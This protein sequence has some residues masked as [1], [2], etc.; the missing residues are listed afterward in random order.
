M[1]SKR[2]LSWSKRSSS[3]EP[4]YRTGGLLPIDT[5]ATEPSNELDAKTALKTERP[6]LVIL[7]PDKQQYDLSPVTDEYNGVLASSPLNPSRSRLKQIEE[8][9]STTTPDLTISKLKTQFSRLR[10]SHEAKVASLVETHQTEVAS[11]RN[12][13]RVLEE[14][15]GRHELH[16]ASIDS[17]P[18]VL[19]TTGSTQIPTRA[20][21]QNKPSHAAAKSLPSIRGPFEGRQTPQNPQENS[22]MVFLRRKLSIPQPSE[23]ETRN[24]APELNQ[25]K[26]NNV[27]LQGQIMS[28]MAKLTES[29]KNERELRSTLGMTEMRCAEWEDKAAHADNLAMKIQALENTIE[30]LESRLEI[31]NTNR[32]DAEE[33]LSNFQGQKSPFDV[34]SSKLE[35]V[36]SDADVDSKENSVV[37]AIVAR[38]ER[39]QEEVREKNACIAELEEDREQLRQQCDQLRQENNKLSIHSDIQEDLLHKTTRTGTDVET[40]QEAINERDAIIAEKQKTIR[41]IA[42]QLEYHKLLLQAEIRKHAAI[43][44]YT[45][46]KDDP[47]PDLTTLAK[48][49]DIDRWMRRLKE[50]LARDRPRGEQDPLLDTPDAQLKS[51][52]HEVDFYVREIILFKLDIKGYRSD[53]RKLRKMTEQMN[54]CERACDHD[55]DVSSLRPVASTP[56]RSAFCTSSPEVSGFNSSPP[57]VDTPSTAT[58]K[59]ECPTSPSLSSPSHDSCHATTPT[60][61]L[62][63]VMT[64]PLELDIPTTLQELME[65]DLGSGTT[66][67]DSN[68]SPCSAL[69]LSPDYRNDF[70]MSFPNLDVPRPLVHKRSI[71]E[72]SLARHPVS[73]LSY[74]P[75][76]FRMNN[77]LANGRT[78]CRSSSTSD[79][80][81]E[82]QQYGA[83]DKFKPYGIRNISVPS[84]PDVPESPVASPVPAT[85][86]T[87]RL[88]MDSAASEADRLP[89]E[90]S[91]HDER[92][93]SVTRISKVPAAT[94]FS[95]VLPK[96]C[97]ITSKAPLK[98]APPTSRR[99]LGGTMAS[100]TPVTSPTSQTAA[101]RQDAPYTPISTNS[102]QA[103][104]APYHRKNSLRTEVQE[105][106]STPPQT[107]A[108]LRN[109]SGTSVRTT[110]RVPD[111]L[112]RLD[113]LA[114][115]P[116][117]DFMTTD[118]QNLKSFDPFAEAD[119]A[120]GEV[121]STQQNYIHIR[122]QQRN[123]RKTLTT[124][125]GLPK[126]FDQKKILKVIKKKFACNG[127]VVADNEM[128]EVIQLQ[129]DQRKDVQD[130]LTD[131]KEG[132]GLDGKTIKVH[133]F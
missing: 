44:L 95:T 122:I 65:D 81:K 99:G 20:C 13:I 107:P 27:A 36:I 133:G 88:R 80:T 64:R 78:H 6:S 53:I 56:V 49:E 114:P 31:A 124:V 126:K 79:T 91:P 117:V 100:S 130:F 72:S 125:Q 129:G 66:R 90:A 39:L 62:T 67:V 35:P 48:R 76:P 42:R 4:Y 97:S 14:Q 73:A 18:F 123:G 108:H 3:S 32:I 8:P 45:S 127:T 89:L 46:S 60:N 69:P 128:G 41:V 1:P 23:T 29:K 70:V 104:F 5:V 21:S 74:S 103:I 57:V 52:Q 119:D 30:D 106:V 131:K 83:F 71:S 112:T 110:N 10:A 94:S 59:A 118:I 43:K 2:I 34:T 111:T 116:P 105:V 92:R 51:L 132:L 87:L 25:F 33:Q 109:V 40:L 12:Q 17:F 68:L 82:M 28:L 22:E 50:R 102:L 38:V 77:T 113:S 26:Q 93:P 96:S 84:L 61:R 115:N 15:N 98:I 55:S 7:P 63:R 121:K 9:K 16:H 11:L 19:D 120:G 86:T 47:L 58:A 54:G 101:F 85:P 37:A 24:L 75:T